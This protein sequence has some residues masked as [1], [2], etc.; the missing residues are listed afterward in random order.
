MIYLGLKQNELSTI[1][2]IARAYDI[3][4]NHLMKVVHKL[5]QLGYIDTVRGKGGGMRLA[6][7]PEQLNIG[8]ILRHTEGQ[9]GLLPCVDGQSDCCIQP[10][11]NFISILSEVQAAIFGVFDRYTLADLLTHKSS[12]S[13]ILQPSVEKH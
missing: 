8:E 10:A 12:L 2:E 9:T 4:E 1:A 5:G 3:S 13:K 6:R 11:C 7:A